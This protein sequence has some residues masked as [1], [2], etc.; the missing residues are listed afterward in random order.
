MKRPTRVCKPHI[1]ADGHCCRLLRAVLSGWAEATDEAAAE[2]GEAA[3]TELRRRLA[4]SEAEGA[5]LA[6]ENRRYGRL[7]DD[8]DW[9]ACRPCEMTSLSHHVAPLSAVWAS[10]CS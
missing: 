9:G 4:A 8:P 1:S 5:R 3:V 6:S 7:I 10:T 2:A